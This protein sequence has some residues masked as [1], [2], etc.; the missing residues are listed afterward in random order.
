MSLRSVTVPA[1][2]ILVGEH[3]VV[4]GGLAIAMPHPTFAM[5]ATY[6]PS[7]AGLSNDL[8]A[9]AREAVTKILSALGANPHGSIAIK[10]DIPLGSGLGSSAALC[11]AITRLMAPELGIAPSEEF[12]VA[13]RCEDQFHGKSSGLDIAA[14]SLGVPIAFQRGQARPL[15]LPQVGVGAFA[16]GFEFRFHDTGLRASTRLTV[17][18]VIAL[19]RPDLDLRMSNA[20][21]RAVEVLEHLGSADALAEIFDET[22]RIYEAWGLVPDQVQEQRRAIL[23]QGARAVRLTGS[24]LGGFLV[25][26]W[27]T[28]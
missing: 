4:R 15:T 21:A 28:P 24:G 1:K 3:A 13:R 8:S 23:A 2:W 5:T 17:E 12:E 27:N 22:H 6:D 18:Q 10:S 26:L 25:S 9:P 11:V 16:Q 14:V 7:Q 19:H 20:A